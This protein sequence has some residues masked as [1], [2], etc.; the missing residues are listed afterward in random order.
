MLLPDEATEL[1]RAEARNPR[2]WLIVVLLS[3]VAAVVPVVVTLSTDGSLSHLLGRTE[4]VSATVDSVRA[5]GTCGRDDNTE[6]RVQV[7]WTLDGNPGRGD[8][9]RCRNAPKEAASVEVW[10]GPDGQVHPDS[11]TTT[12]VGLTFLAFVLVVLVWSLGVRTIVPP[13]RRRRRLLAAGSRQLAQPVPVEL[14]VGKKLRMRIAVPAQISGQ[15]RAVTVNPVLC[16]GDGSPPTTRLRPTMIGSYWLYLAPDNGSRR[17]SG[18][19][20]RGQRRCWIDFT[21]R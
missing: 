20:V 5:A 8:Y 10:V 1:R 19:L 4:A 15:E 2:R 21:P 17:R 7:R 12:L 6:Y 14:L 16:A 13:S 18:L 9:L 3:L 11:P